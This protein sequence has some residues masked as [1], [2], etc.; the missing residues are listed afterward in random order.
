MSKALSTLISPLIKTNPISV[1][2]LGICSALAIT[3]QLDT[4]ITMCAAVTFVTAASNFSISLIR[5]HVPAEIR[6][7]VEM[8]IIAALVI[9]VDQCLQ[10]FAYDISRQ[11]SIFVGLIIT[12]CIVMGRTEAF[13][14]KNGPWLSTLDGIGNGLGYSLVLLI[15]GTCRELFGY[16]TL[17]GYRILPLTS[18][19]GWYQSNGLMLLSPGAFFLIGGFIWVIRTVKPELI[20]NE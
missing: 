14:L 7:I 8:T 11:M 20:E 18:D 16:G 3:G 15:V 2:I 1:Q 9:F 6:M 5:N 10:A 12:N 17:L 4:T 19:G 13:A